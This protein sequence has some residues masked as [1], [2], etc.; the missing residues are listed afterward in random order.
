LLKLD[1]YKKILLKYWGY[2]SFRPLQEDIIQSVA[3]GKDT[4]ALMPTGGGKSLTF[5]IPALAKDGLCIVITPLIAL[6][7]DQV[8]RLNHLGIKAIAIYSGL[9]KGE[10][11]I[12]LNNCIYGDFKFL[13][14]SP[15]RLTT[16]IFNIRLE[17]M[18]VNLLAIDEA[19]CIS[20][21]GYDFRPSYLQI[22]KIREKLPQT[23]IL[24]LTATATHAVAD[25]IME[26]LCFKNKNIIKQSFERKNLVYLVRE[27]EDKQD[28]VLKSI[29]NFKTSG[30]VYVRN[31]QSTKDIAAFLNKNGIKSDFYHAGL[32]DEQRNQKQNQW[33]DNKT[34][35]IV[36]T[37]AFGMGIDKP[38]VRFVIHYDIPDSIEA[39]FQEA[40][41]GGRDG[42]KAYAVLLHN[43]TTKL[44][45]NK[46]IESNFPEINYI[47]QMYNL[48]GNF[49]QIPIG[50]GKFVGYD[51]SIADFATQ[52]KLSIHT[53]YSALKILSQEGYIELTDEINNPSRV[54]FNVNRDDLYKFQ[55]ENESYD[56]FIKLLL[57]SYTGL[58]NNYVPIDELMLSKRA[59]IGIETVYKILSKLNHYNIIRYIPK[60]NKP[61]IIYTEERLDDK[62]LYIN[63]ER[64][65]KL[66]E[67]YIQ[68][69]LSMLH[70]AESDN[71]CRSVILL[72]YFGEKEPVRC[73]NCDVCLRRNEL[74]LSK[75]EFDLILEQIKEIADGQNNEEDMI[76]KIEAMYPP[77]KT[78][79]VIRWLLDNH[80]II[81]NA[82]GHIFWK[83]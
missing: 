70:Y 52:Y 9:S 1:I 37:N 14:C 20:Q 18:N 28:Y 71:K 54:F 79:Q 60:R 75:Y 3:E 10:I 13:Y 57:R 30:I 77:E 45:V 73:G 33:K 39:Y 64:Y 29:Q 66:K 65:N 63:I 81:K 55:V 11:D 43:N 82:E 83:S 61:M 5:Q 34:P 51:F 6:M 44:T 59:N 48:L 8:D 49:F 36:A 74:G 72:E 47:K 42:K 41:R 4:L 35:V 46:R 56:G 68:R 62:N 31:R 25:D 27:T 2:G 24:A 23:P 69:S 21:W 53:A 19:H 50:A 26:K 22:A 40:G 78:I 32:T 12:A 17:K 16:E 76:L 15:E 80:K 7:K 67:L 58:F 38:D